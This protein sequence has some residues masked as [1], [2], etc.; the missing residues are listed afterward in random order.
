MLAHSRNRRTQPRRV[1]TGGSDYPWFSDDGAW[2][3]VRTYSK[4]VADYTDMLAHEMNAQIVY[5]DPVKLDKSAEVADK[6]STGYGPEIRALASKMRERMKV[7]GAAQSAK[8]LQFADRFHPFQT[9]VTEWNNLMHQTFSAS[10][11]GPKE[12]W[13]HTQN[14]ETRLKSFQAEYNTLGGTKPFKLP[15]TLSTPTG[16]PESKIPWTGL[17]IVGGLI[18]GASILRSFT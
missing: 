15:E 17:L 8:D 5:A 6:Y 18:A 3:Y 7:R 2:P 16:E 1:R 13:N 14:L 12:S 9:E 11:P 10:R 4:N